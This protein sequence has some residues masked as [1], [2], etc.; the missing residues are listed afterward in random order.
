MALHPAYRIAVYVPPDHLD[1]VLEA[2]LRHTPLQ[3]GQY[4]RVAHWTSVGVEQFRP[5]SGAS[6]TVGGV[7][8]V[9]RL[10]TVLLEFAI[11]R[12]RDLL[13]S[14]VSDLART[15]PWEEP[16]MFVDE[17]FVTATHLDHA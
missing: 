3:F 14:I 7:G 6:P 5:L 11:P 15:H 16:V 8:H 4:D 13:D 1:A 10:E 12:D 9:S 2:A 17:T